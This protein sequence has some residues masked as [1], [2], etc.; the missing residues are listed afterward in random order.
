MIFDKDFISQLLV[1]ADLSER[2]RQ[3]F[4]LR[5]S[6]ADT[7]QRMLN[8]LQPG[9]KVPVH[10][11]VDTAETVICVCGKM[12][13][14]FYESVN[15]DNTEFKEISRTLLCPTDGI[16]GMQIEAG[17]WHSINVIVPSVIFEA[18]DGAYKG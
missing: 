18:K 8:A 5:N 16:Y 15:A 4:D 17:V 3:N 7:S 14:I 13:E 2:Q 9:T 6:D 10:R 12:E 11:H 1:K